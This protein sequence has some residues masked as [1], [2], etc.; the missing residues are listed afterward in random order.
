MTVVVAD[1]SPINYL[2]L[3]GEI[4]VLQRLYHSVV[5][6]EDVFN[7]LT[8]LGAPPEVR[9]WATQQPAWI[10]IRKVPSRD[11]AL[12]DWMLARHPRSR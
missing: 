2:V 10:E 7:E 8:D 3:I 11:I 12:V 1:T 9:A 4:D 6:P 5:I